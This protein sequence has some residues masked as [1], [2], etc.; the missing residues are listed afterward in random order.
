MITSEMFKKRPDQTAYQINL[1]LD[2]LETMENTIMVRSR[3]RDRVIII[4]EQ[5]IDPSTRKPYPFGIHTYEI[6]GDRLEEI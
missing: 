1:I 5:P 6:K 2:R 4:G 3:N